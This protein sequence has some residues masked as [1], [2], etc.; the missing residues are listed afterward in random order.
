MQQEAANELAGCKRHD[1]AV[2]IL[3]IVLPAKA[4]VAGRQCD[5]PAVGDG[6]AMSVTG[7]IGEN[8]GRAGERTFGKDHPFDFAQGSDI[9]L[10]RLPGPETGSVLGERS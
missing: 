6:D 3:T 7:K 5:E 4:D 8:L 2:A 9:R 10:E 1:L